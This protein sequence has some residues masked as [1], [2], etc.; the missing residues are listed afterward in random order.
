MSMAAALVIHVGE[1][2][3]T[4]IVAGPNLVHA[5][6]NASFARHPDGRV[7]LFGGHGPGFVSM[8]SAEV[9]R[10]DAAAFSGLNMRFTHD[11]PAIARLADGRVLLA[12]GS[13]NLGVPAYAHA[14]IFDPADESFTVTGNMVRFR[15]G[16]GAAT[17]T[18]GRVLIASAWYVHNDA[19][20]YGELFDP[21]TGRFTATSAL[22][23]PRS[24]AFVV[25]LQD[26][27]ALVMGGTGP[28]GGPMEGRVE[29]FNPAEGSFS[30]VQ[31]LLFVGEAGWRTSGGNLPV[32]DL[33]LADGRFVNVATRTINSI[34]ETVLFTVDPVSG[35]IVKLP[36]QSPLPDSSQVNFYAPPI[37]SRDGS[38]VF[39]LGNRTGTSPLQ[40]QVARIQ[41]ATG[42][43]GLPAVEGGFDGY[44][45]S[46][47]AMAQV[48]DGRLLIAG[49][50]T[51][52]NFQAVAGTR[53]VTV[54]QDEPE[55]PNLSVIL[56]NDVPGQPAL[57]FS[58]P[59]GGTELVLE[60]A[61]QLGATWRTVTAERL[62]EEGWVR[63]TLPFASDVPH[64]FLRLRLP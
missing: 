55:I 37:V 44:Y 50:T 62:V 63:V 35:S 59:V 30:S 57:R 36:L 53:L 10:P 9:W 43:V 33:R 6:M 58:W 26:G 41:V 17:L 54:G 32:D 19:H 47:A 18:D 64:R 52:N 61:E 11:G 49:G 24:Y 2:A 14:E 23:T 28:T 4:Q 29:R 51:G 34:T 60:D 20:T 38:E 21:A 8:A 42:K 12:G 1:A 13:S 15:A 39:L 56:Q 16:A 5:R 46:Y 25:P 7:F 3:P 40:Y 22:H 31:D 45:P 27:G 48:S